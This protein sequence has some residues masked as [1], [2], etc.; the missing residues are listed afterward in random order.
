MLFL[1]DNAWSHTPEADGLLEVVLATKGQDLGSGQLP[2]PGALQSLLVG[3]LG[4]TLL[5]FM[6]SDPVSRD[7]RPAISPL[8][9]AQSG[10]LA[11]WGPPLPQPR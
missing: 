5:A 6:V 1:L 8:S 11:V 7:L 10:V 3:L 9:A 2:A 4:P